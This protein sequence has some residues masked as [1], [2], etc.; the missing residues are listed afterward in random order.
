MMKSV[1]ILLAL[2]LFSSV[3]L[4]ECRFTNGVSAEVTGAITFGEVVVQR[5]APIGSVIATTTTGPYNGGNPIAG[6][7]EDWL[8][9]WELSK[10]N[11]LSSLSNNIYSTNVPGVGLRLTN[12]AAKEMIPYSRQL[13]ADVYI[14]IPGDGIKAELIKTGNIADGVLDAGTLARV[15]IVGDF[16]FANLVLIGTNTVRTESCT[17]T[18]PAVD[19]ILD[20]HD[21]KEFSGIGSGSAWKEFN[22]ELTCQQGARINIR[23]DALADL[24]TNV[25]GVIKLDN[26]AISARGVGVQVRYRKDESP[27]NLGLEKYY[28]ISS[29][30]GSEQ[31]QLQ[32]R[33]YQTLETITPGKANATATFTLSYK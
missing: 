30:G 19:V 20:K 3:T 6:C 22:I 13:A 8:Y 27:V 32:A 24:D 25:A 29:T 26:D 18:T 5:D 7:T 10:W 1:Y 16:Y 23:I 12:T 21:K 17:V 4:A 2:W 14:A 28:Q 15:S 31:I 33:Y 9:R 11:S